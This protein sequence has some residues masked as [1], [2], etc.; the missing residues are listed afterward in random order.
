VPTA[1]QNQYYIKSM[2]YA[3]LGN[4]S[5][6]LSNINS[7]NF[8]I[9]NGSLI[10]SKGNTLSQFFS[11]ENINLTRSGIYDLNNRSPPYADIINAMLFP[12]CDSSKSHCQVLSPYA[13]EFD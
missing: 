9:A 4:Y 7:W 1:K 5:I 10:I 2:S 3:N 8:N 6:N 13:F 11:L 12:R